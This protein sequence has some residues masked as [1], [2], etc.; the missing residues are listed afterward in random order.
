MDNFSEWLKRELNQRGWSQREL[1]RRAG[2]S[3]T[4]INDTINQKTRPGW[5]L[6]TAIARAFDMSEE[7]VFRIA[8]LL[9]PLPD[10]EEGVTYQQL[11]D[12][13]KRMS[14][15]ERGEVYRY[16]RYRLQREQEEKKRRKNK[17]DSVG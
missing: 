5:D 16:A 14:P 11:W 9:P 15:E 1:A 4:A 6:C 2:V 3:A 13:V 8:T 17:G 12:I 10:T 7:E